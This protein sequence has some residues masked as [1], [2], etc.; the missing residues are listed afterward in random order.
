MRSG[1]TAE[2][3]VDGA[4]RH[5]LGPRGRQ[6]YSRHRHG[7]IPEVGLANRAGS[8]IDWAEV[9]LILGCVSRKRST[10]SAARDLYVSPL[11]ERRRRYAERSGRPWVIFSAANG[12]VDPET[13]LAPYDVTL[14]TASPAQKRAMGERVAGQ[15][16]DRFGLLDGRVF[17]IH[18]G[19]AYVDALEPALARRGS[20]LVNPVTGLRIGEQ[21]HW[22]DSQE[23]P[24]VIRPGGDLQRT[25]AHGTATGARPTEESTAVGRLQIVD[26]KALEP[27][28]FRWP[29]DIEEFQRGWNFTVRAGSGIAR[30]RI[31]VGHRKVYG[32]D[33]VHTVTWLNGQPIV[34]GVAAD[35]YEDSGG[36]ISLLRIAGRAMVRH[37]GE[38]PSG[39]AGFQV[40]DHA[41]EIR[42]RYT[43]HGLAV[44]LDEDDLLGWARHA[45]LRARSKAANAEA[46]PPGGPGVFPPR[47]SPAL[48]AAPPSPDQQAVVAALL[49]H[50]K[51]AIDLSPAE[52]VFT[53]NPDA[54]RLVVEDPFAFLLAVILDQGIKAERAWAGPYLLKLRLGHLDPARIAADPGAVENAVKTPPTL[55]R[56]VNKIP[57]WIVA[58]AARVLRHYDGDAARIWT[59]Q[60]AQ[61]V[62]RR[63]DA[64]EGIGQKKA[65]MA[66]EILARDLHVPVRDLEGSDIAYDVHVRRVFLRTGLAERDDLDHM[67]AVARALRPE[68]PGEIDFPAWNIGRT[69]CR[70]GV[71]LCPECPLLSVCPR[72][73][74]MAEGV[75]GA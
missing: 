3:H 25:E 58:A 73:V 64:F 66:V 34:E 72:L 75:S 26:I 68:R 14:K 36:L 57:A 20:S 10:P 12:I 69:W 49:A 67:V 47:P 59:N 5:A 37:A 28:T 9:P 30:V 48:L 23:D 52:P 60:S 35:D 55:Q 32:M 44:K 50:A 15:L 39:Y 6:P 54:N 22:Y 7:G 46:V 40:V 1:P 63:L 18:A 16:E 45:L 43:R 70:P 33:R 27:F 41:A 8:G 2:Q 42:A 71:P 51:S 61:E 13:A 4:L 53:P 38:L 24:G 21:L 56:Y 62:Q 11:F 17:E 65:A 31:G 74:E 29:T 19:A